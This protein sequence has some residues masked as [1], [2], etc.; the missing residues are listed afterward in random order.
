MTSDQ[1]VL[2][3]G[4]SRGIAAATAVAAARRGWSVLL[5]YRSD[6]ASAKAVV[7]EC[8]AI[9]VRA[10]AVQFDAADL[11]AVEPLFAQVDG[12]GPTGTRSGRGCSSSATPTSAASR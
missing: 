1:L 8:T 12:F 6:S 3:T 2:V 7:E 5:T 10:G 4:G 9:G 11:G